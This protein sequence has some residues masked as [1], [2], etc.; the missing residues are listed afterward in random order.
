[1]VYSSLLSASGS[2][3]LWSLGRGF[4]VMS[5]S[6]PRSV[7][8]N[9]LKL[10]IFDTVVPVVVTPSHGILLLLFLSCNFATLRNSNVIS[11][12]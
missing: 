12:M 4:D 1:M 11:D 10:W 8:L 9:L 7:V 2:P 3:P 6:Y 5:R